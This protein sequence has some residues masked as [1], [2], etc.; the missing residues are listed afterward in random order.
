MVEVRHRLEGSV[1][2]ERT[3]D[4][5]RRAI[6][7]VVVFLKVGYMR[8]AM[9]WCVFGWLKLLQQVIP[10]VP[11]QKSRPQFNQGCSEMKLKL[12]ERHSCVSCPGRESLPS[13][14]FLWGV[15]MKEEKSKTEIPMFS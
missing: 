15:E 1:R 14:L 10:F 13:P 9:E 8:V 6:M 4:E 7:E 12:S 3:R 2:E 11:F 5:E